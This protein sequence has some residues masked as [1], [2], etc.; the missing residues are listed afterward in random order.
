MSW[1]FR[2]ATFIDPPAEDKIRLAREEIMG[3]VA[4]ITCRAAFGDAVIVFAIFL[5]VR[6][7]LQ[8]CSSVLKGHRRTGTCR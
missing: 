6:L 5:T 4:R 2:L 3:Y 1:V 8:Q 7:P